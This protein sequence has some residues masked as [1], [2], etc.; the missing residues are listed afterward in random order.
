MRRQFA[1]QRQQQRALGGRRMAQGFDGALDFVGPGHE[2]E[3]IA[4]GFA[5]ACGTFV[6]GGRGIPWRIVVRVQGLGQMFNRDRKG[7]TV[8]MQVGAGFEIRLQQARIQRGGHHHQQ[9]IR[10]GGLLQTQRLRQGDI[11]I[12]VALVEFV[13]QDGGH[14]RQSRLGEHLAQQNAFGFKM[15]ACFWSAHRFQPHLIAHFIAQ[16]H[17]AFFGHAFGQQAC[18]Q[19]AR[20]E[21]H[22][23]A[24]AQ[25]P[26]IQQHLRHLGGFS[27]ACGGRQDDPPRTFQRSG[28]LLTN[29]INRQ[30]GKA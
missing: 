21:H 4:G 29:G 11:A 25:R 13:E 12:D 1:M 26:R 20:L 18:R 19:T 9:Q 10:A 6:G 27:G 3:R 8:R 15:N 30:H 22:D 14:P 16:R 17:A 28:Q 7:A 5:G 23:L 2:D 24:G